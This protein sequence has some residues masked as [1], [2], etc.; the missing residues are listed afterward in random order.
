MTY[1]PRIVEI[2]FGDVEQV[3]VGSAY[4]D[5][6]RNRAS[7]RL[8]GPHGAIVASLSRKAVRDLRDK[9]EREA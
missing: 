3:D 8:V 7:I 1:H 9:L 5:F 2:T 4:D 6:P